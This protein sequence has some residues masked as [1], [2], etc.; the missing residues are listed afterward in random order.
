MVVLSLC[1]VLIGTTLAAETAINSRLRHFVISPFL[2]SIISFIVGTIFLIAVLLLTGGSLTFPHSVIQDNPWWLWTGGLWGTIYMTANILLFPILGAV[3]T[4]VLPIMG[5]IIMGIIIDQFGLFYSPQHSLTI[6]TGIGMVLVIVGVLTTTYQ[7]TTTPQFAKR[8]IIWQ[9]AGVISGGFSSTQTAINGHLGIVLHSPI[10]AAAISFTISVIF[11]IIICLALKVPLKPVGN[12]VHQGI[13]AWW[14][15]IGGLLGGIF[16]VGN[17]WLAP[18]LGTGQ[19]VV[20]TLF[21]QLLFSAIIDRFGLFQS[22]V[23]GVPLNKI[24]GLVIMFGGVIL[25]KL[26]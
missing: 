22:A 19:V 17:T 11:L 7:R 23:K 13:R 9:V 14:L 15:W 25:T 12:A 26:V 16:V 21:G 24:I 20:L 1:G 6:I 5:Q 18:Q 10:H 8:K 4:S 2:A 3:Q